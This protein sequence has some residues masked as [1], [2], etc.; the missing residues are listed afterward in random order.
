MRVASVAVSG[1]VYRLAEATIDNAAAFNFGNVHVGDTLSQA[2]SIS[3]TAVADAFSESLNASF[4]A[5]SDARITTN[6]GAINQLAAGGTDNSGMVVNVATTAAGSVNGTVTLNFASDGTGTSG[7]GITGLPSQDLAVTASISATAYR[8][9]NPVINN[10]QPIAFGNFR[11]G[12]AVTAQ[13]VSITNDC[14]ERRVVGGTECGRQWHHRWCP[15]QWWFVQPA[16]AAGHR[17][18]RHHGLDRHRDGG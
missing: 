13:A 11:E 1:A 17:Q 7:L 10:T 5:I 3:N 16:G 15:D 2:I 4:G 8:L 6:G 9:A 18:H 12:D 14:A